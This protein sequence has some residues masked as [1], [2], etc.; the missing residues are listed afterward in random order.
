MAGMHK[1]AL[2]SD[3]PFPRGF[4]RAVHREPLYTQRPALPDRA[5]S[6]VV[7]YTSLSFSE[8]CSIIIVTHRNNNRNTYITTSIETS[9]L[10]YFTSLHYQ[11]HT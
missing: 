2:A 5:F 8:T 1:H 10:P 3:L 11:L 9:V 7:D 6:S 4:R